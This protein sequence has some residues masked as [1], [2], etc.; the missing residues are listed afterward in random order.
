MKLA[1]ACTLL[2]LAGSAGADTVPTVHHLPAAEAE[3]GKDLELI[4]AAPAAIPKLTA[5]YRRPG[6]ASY[7]P[8]ELVRRDDRRW[9]AVVPAGA[10]A[11]PGL[12][13]YLD[14]GGAPVFASATAPHTTRVAVSVSEAR[15]ARDEARTQRR[16]SRV[17]TS[18]EWV[19]FGRHVTDRNVEP[20]G[21][22]EKKLRDS[23]YRIDAE[24]SYRLWAYPLEELRVGYTRLIG[25]AETRCKLGEQEPCE[26]Q[27][28]FKVAGWFELGVSPI[29]GV[30]LDGRAI[31]LA[32]QT[33]FS[34]GGRAEIRVGQRDATHVA[35]GVESIA[36]VGTSG[37]FR[38]GW[39]TVPRTPMAATIEITT[40]P[41]T[42]NEAG[43]RLFYDVAHQ[44]HDAVRLGVRVG[45]AARDQDLGGIT[46][47]ANATFDF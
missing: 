13:Y 4:A 26:S 8:I 10:V 9:V 12:E 28:G 37:Y 21:D 3:A 34:L 38:F 43:I 23:Y 39:G 36:D 1:I 22:P 17:H 19:D 7:A 35:S 29:D 47:G 27:A 30:G 11:A 41:A 44:L 2:A 40:L 14:A 42:N 31:V 6:A 25:T 18:F 20:F 46:G 5:H 45:Y 15:R 16:R 24:F 33:G 32:T